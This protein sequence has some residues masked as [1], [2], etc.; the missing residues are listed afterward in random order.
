MKYAQ[1]SEKEA[2]DCLFDDFGKN[3]LF[4]TLGKYCKRYSNLKREKDLL[5]IATYCFILWLKR[6]F[7]L[8]E[9]GTDEIINTTVEVKSNYFQNFKDEFI[10]YLG[11]ED[12]G[13]AVVARA[14]ALENIYNLLYAFSMI[15]FNEIC[16]SDLFDIFYCCYYIWDT[17]IPSDKKEK[18]EDVG[19]IN[20]E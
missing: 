7:H 4:G 12:F 5:K 1:T 8:D 19:K 3:W 13:W 14:K 20:K 11:T 2:T 16:E 17:E 10:G 15:D 18:D 9:E 6:G